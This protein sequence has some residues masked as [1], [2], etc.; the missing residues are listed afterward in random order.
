MSNFTETP[1]ALN[2]PMPD[3]IPY[4]WN[5]FLKIFYG[6]ISVLGVFGNSLTILAVLTNKFLRTAPF[7][8]VVSLTCVDLIVCGV[9][10]PIG[11][12]YDLESPP[13]RLCQVSKMFDF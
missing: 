8:F 3:G 7:S 13:D 5:F 6:L 2:T 12:A 10:L 1:L 11:I 4:H 9:L